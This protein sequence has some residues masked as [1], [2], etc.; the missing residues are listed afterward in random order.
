M[1]AKTDGISLA[2]QSATPL[3]GHGLGISL[4]THLQPQ[5][6][7]LAGRE[8]WAGLRPPVLADPAKTQTPTPSQHCWNT[9][10]QRFAEVTP[11]HSQHAVLHHSPRKAI[12]LSLWAARCR[13]APSLAEGRLQLYSY[14][15]L[16][17]FHWEEADCTGSGKEE[18]KTFRLP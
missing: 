10:Q 18:L 16:A 8:P 13:Q 14:F 9:E 2:A 17:D 6:A 3:F 1:E 4:Q 5:C 12:K 15:V 7:A 11:E